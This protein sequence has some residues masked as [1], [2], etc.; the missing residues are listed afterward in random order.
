MAKN[1]QPP[2]KSPIPAV[3]KRNTVLLT[4]VQALFSGAFQSV[5]VIAALGIFYFTHSAALGGLASAVAIGGRVL[6]AYGAGR[7]MDRVGR[8]TVLYAGIAVS[9]SA[10]ALMAYALYYSSIWLFWAGIF[11]FGTGGGIM[12]LLRVPVTDM[13]PASRRGEGMGYLLTGSIAGTF[14]A[15]VLAAVAPY[16]D[17]A[18]LGTYVIILL[19][20]VPIMVSGTVFV[21]LISPDTKEI[22]SNLKE[23]YPQE[24]LGVAAAGGGSKGVPLQ[25]T[26]VSG[27][28]IA[29]F[30]TSAFSWGGMVMGMSLVSIILQG[31]GVSL[32]LINI[33][34]SIHV[35]GM[36]GLSIPM[37]WL[38]DRYGRKIVIALGG[39][40]LGAG[41]FLMPLTSDYII[42]TLG[43]FL[44]GLG[45]S[46]TNVA[47]T[48]LLCDLTPGP[49]RGS[50][51]GA[52]DVVT[53][54]TSVALPTLGG[55]I[56]SSLGFVAFGVA[57]I[58]VALPVVLGALPIKETVPQVGNQDRGCPVT[59][60]K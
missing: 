25:G 13:Y 34:V 59:V 19:I 53:G 55:A 1:M 26:A 37:G 33:A 24:S 3:I 57:G 11:L 21:K 30:I 49:K 58:V 5:M 18:G 16:L 23:Y 40:I 28:I 47:S 52:N 15:P 12:N 50:I 27:S 8:K 4:I 9:C 45:W 20:T 7:L 46:A 35:F 48:A 31:Y 29:A 2:A 38:T 54:V 60:K 56:L 10:I 39:F 14:M 43:V 36:F 6:V 41:A 42:I 22:L 51:L 32:T 17:F 44:I